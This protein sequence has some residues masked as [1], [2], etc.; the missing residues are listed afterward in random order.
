MNK[1]SPI[2]KDITGVTNVKKLNLSARMENNSYSIRGN[3][4]KS[5]GSGGTKDYNMLINHPRINGVELIGDKNC[6]EL[7]VQEPITLASENDIDNI[8]FGI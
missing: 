2:Q 7:K 5:S 3:L 1:I 6:Q 4:N 8:I